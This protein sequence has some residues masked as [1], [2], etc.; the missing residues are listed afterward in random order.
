M[1]KGVKGR[2][3]VGKK[4]RGRG[5]GGEGEGRKRGGET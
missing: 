3:G 4:E 2:R 1:A 5:I